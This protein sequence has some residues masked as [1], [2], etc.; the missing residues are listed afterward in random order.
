M[1]DATFDAFYDRTAADVAR[2]VYLLTASPHRAAHVTHQAYAR[3]YADWETVSQLPAPESWV[4]MIAADLALN[5]LHRAQQR[6]SGWMPGMDRIAHAVRRITPADTGP[7]AAKPDEPTPEARPKATAPDAE[8]VEAEPVAAEPVEPEPVEPEPAEAAPATAAAADAAP[9]DTASP[10]PP[11]AKGTRANHR[12]KKGRK[13]Q[14][15]RATADPKASVSADAT[16]PAPPLNPAE[17]PEAPEAP[18]PSPPPQSPTPPATPLP[19]PPPPDLSSD[20]SDTCDRDWSADVA[21]LRALRRIPAHRRRAV[22]LHHSL[23]MSPEDIAAE[24][25]STTGSTVERI[26]LANQQLASRV[27]ELTGPAPDSDEAHARISA[28]MAD[29]S[30]RYDPK[31]HSAHLVRVGAHTRA[32]VL[33]VAVVAALLVLGGF[34]LAAVIDPGGLPDKRAEVQASISAREAAGIKIVAKLPKPEFKIGRT[35][36][37]AAQVP[38]G[39]RELVYITGTTNRDGGVFLLVDSAREGR[40]AIGVP[41]L[42]EVP[43]APN[44]RFRAEVTFGL[45]EEKIIDAWDFLAKVRD[46]SLAK[47]AFEL[48]YDEDDQV[49]RVTEYSP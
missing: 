42:R 38:D 36:A 9:P 2:H 49:D 25:E 1:D 28:V 10:P 14:P 16:A 24:T 6:I 34:A 48:H 39:K 30:R 45:T 37:K 47:H 22:V 11:P 35:N 26:S 8:P 13:P 46:G 7:A 3:V 18:A 43:L 33:A 40:D 29:L 21:L 17:A 31:L 5:H 4:R 12:K 15:D 20:K 44:V 23:G 27:G 32:G 41:P 19:S